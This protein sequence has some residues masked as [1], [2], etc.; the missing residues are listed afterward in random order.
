M[1]EFD[2][3][4]QQIDWAESRI[5][6]ARVEI[7]RYIQDDAFRLQ[8]DV[9]PQTGEHVRKI[10][11]VK[12]VPISVKGNLRNAVVDLKH[13]FDM[14]LHAATRALGNS[15]FDKN[16]P[17]ADSPMSVRGIVDKWQCKANTAVA[18][19][20]ID[21]IWRQEPY[22]T[23]EGYTGG[24]DL[25]REIAKMAN[26]KHSIGIGASAQISSISIGKI[27]IDNARSFSLFQGWNPKKKEMVLSRHIGVVSYDNPDATGDVVFERVGRLGP[28][29]AVTT[30]LHFLE[31]AKLCVQ[32]FESVVRASKG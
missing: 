11:L 20:I 27:H 31:R 17:W 16:F 23:G 6:S 26:N 22:A 1:S 28:L 25:A 7:A 2:E 9:N 15:R 10:V 12:D 21:E 14:T 13:S 32:G 29:S 24:D 5:E 4:R 3:V 19:A 30:A 8:E 18:Q